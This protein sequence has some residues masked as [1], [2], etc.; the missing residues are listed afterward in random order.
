MTRW[1]SA[2]LRIAFNS[3]QFTEIGEM[4]W[5][6]R[7]HFSED[8]CKI[9]AYRKIT[10]TAKIGSACL[11]SITAVKNQRSSQ[12]TSWVSDKYAVKRAN[13]RMGRGDESTDCRHQTPEALASTTPP[14]VQVG[15]T[16]WNQD[17]GFQERQA[18]CCLHPRQ[19]HRTEEPALGLLHWLPW[20]PVG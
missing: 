17:T 15:K 10:K 13:S 8:K 3:K 19:S 16:S 1:L 6:H 20:K 5:K 9:Y 4:V 18:T 7:M 12:I 14:A 11:G 2:C